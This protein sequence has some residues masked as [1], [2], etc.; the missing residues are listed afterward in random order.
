M[1]ALWELPVL[2][3]FAALF[4]PRLEPFAGDTAAGSPLTAEAMPDVEPCSFAALEPIEDAAAQEFEAGASLDISGMRHGAAR[5]LEQFQ[6]RVESVGGTLI[7]KSAYRP[8]AYQRHL[9]NVWHAWM[10][11]LRDNQEPGC[12]ELRTQVGDEFTRHHLIETQHPVAESD[13]TRGLAFDALVNLPVR[14][15]TR[16]RRVTLDRLARRV[17]LLRP[18]IVADPVHFKYI[19]A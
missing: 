11:Q 17:G 5:A 3:V 9:Q 18:A 4:H 19:G 14:A 15:R 7:L 6:S 2:H 8:A 16:N 13:H 10:N 12:Q 1:D